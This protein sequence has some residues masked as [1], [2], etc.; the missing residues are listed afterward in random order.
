MNWVLNLNKEKGIT[1]NKAV[2]ILK[3]MFKVKKAGHVGTLDPL[4]T[5][6]L[7]I[8]FNEATKISNYLL[9]LDKE[10]I[11]TMKLGEVTDTYDSEGRILSFCPDFQISLTDIIKIVNG[12]IGYIEQT[13][14]LYSAVKVKGKPLY[15]YAR[16]GLEVD[17][18]PRRVFINSIDL[19]EYRPPFLTLK[20]VCSR[21]TFIR[22]L[23]HDIGQKLGVGAHLTEL[24]RTRIGHF[25][26]SNSSK[27]EELLDR[28][29]SIYSIDQALMHMPEVVLD[30]PF[31]VKRFR[32][33]NPIKVSGRYDIESIRE[34]PELVKVKDQEGEVIGIGRIIEG[35]LKPGRLFNLSKKSI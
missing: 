10:Y 34:T 15:K 7:L 33:G 8:C 12:F 32:N 19:I 4:A 5:G 20:V 22:S 3:R 9:S 18:K 1:S 16:Q 29:D 24:T 6:V 14:P 31:S 25:T 17:L 2:T 26:I 35:W 21:G 13:P 11:A 27:I 30:D 23:C 28:K